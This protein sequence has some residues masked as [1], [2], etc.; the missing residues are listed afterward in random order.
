MKRQWIAMMSIAVL[1][2]AMLSGCGAEVSSQS[3]ETPAS[4]V[5]IPDAETA[6]AVESTADTADASLQLGD[7]L[8][9]PKKGEEIAVIETTQGTIKLRLFP[10]EAP[11]T[12]E[13]FKTLATD[14][15]YDGLPF[16]RIIDNF[17]IQTG[18]SSSTSIYGGNFEDEFSENL[19]NLRGAVSMANVGAA[20]TNGTQFFINQTPADH[21]PGWDN[22]LNGYR[23]Y[24][25]NPEGFTQVYGTWP[26]MSK[27]TMEIRE[28][29]EKYGGNP[30]LDG[31]YTTTGLGHTVFGQVFE[32][33][34]VVDRIAKA[35]VDE[36]Q[37][38]VSDDYKIKT[39]TI[40]TYEG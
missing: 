40:T 34:D 21:F 38:P 19:L 16:H 26:D 12:V 23:A 4:Q 33:M 11:K 22:I 29:Y 30:S 37:K 17:M 25:Q 1:S 35:K 13:N 20:D 7:Q 5:S 14:G 24:M 36:N 6:S 31:A 15:V 3:S 8:K 10:Q 2:A 9:K 18:Q 32:G 28:L 27:V 39:I